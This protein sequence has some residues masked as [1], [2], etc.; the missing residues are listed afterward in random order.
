MSYKR[1]V[2]CGYCGQTGHNKRSCPDLLSSLK[3]GKRA[4]TLITRNALNVSRVSAK[5]VPSDV[6]IVAKQDIRLEPATG[7]KLK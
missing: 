1:T 6:V 5:D 7:T 3:S 4:T 2:R